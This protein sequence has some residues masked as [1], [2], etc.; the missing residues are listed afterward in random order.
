VPQTDSSL[1][2]P[3]RAPALGGAAAPAGAAAADLTQIYRAHAADVSRWARRLLGPQ[4]DA[5]DVV[6]EVFLVA[7]RRLPEWRGE[8]KITTWLYAIT[9]RVVRERRRRERLRGW[10]RL[11]LRA[12]PDEAPPPTPLQSLESRRAM[13]T[14]YRILD[15]LPDRERTAFI[16]FELEGL[17]GE[18]IAAVTGDSVGSVWVRLHRARARF[19]EAFARTE[20]ATRE[21]GP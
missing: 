18:E 1:D 16:L 9:V 5:E 13:E 8:A 21:D 7:H 11:S 3:R 6:H 17:S 15:G 19:R 2:R 20:Q 12:R 10:L 14:T 4:G